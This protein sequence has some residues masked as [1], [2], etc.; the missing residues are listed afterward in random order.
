MRIIF[1]HFFW[2][3]IEKKSLLNQPRKFDFDRYQLEFKGII[4]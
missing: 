1:K 3:I 4:I 2:K